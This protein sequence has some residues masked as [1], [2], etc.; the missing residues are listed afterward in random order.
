MQLP[1]NHHFLLVTWRL[2]THFCCTVTEPFLNSLTYIRNS[3]NNY[4]ISIIA[5]ACLHFSIAT[6]VGAC[7][8]LYGVIK[9][10]AS[11]FNLI[12]KRPNNAAQLN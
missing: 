4:A 10:H 8:S 12:S 5:H 2:L 3:T 6:S 9:H 11:Y 1:S 7:I